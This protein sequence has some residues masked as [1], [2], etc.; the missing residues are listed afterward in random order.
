MGWKLHAPLIKVVFATVLA[1]GTALAFHLRTGDIEPSLTWSTLGWIV[2]GAVYTH[3][4]EYF[5]HLQMMH[6]VIRIARWRFYDTRHLA[7]HRL[8]AGDNFQTRRPEHL[9][10]VT[11]R[12][13][14]FPALFLLHY[15]A[16]RAIFPPDWAPAFF[17]GV[18]VQFLVYEVSHWL[19]HLAEN[20]LD[21]WVRRVP[22]LGD[23]RRRQ[24]E[25]HRTHH[26]RPDVN[27]NFTPP[28]A[29]DYLGRTRARGNMA[30]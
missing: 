19:T 8:F 3:L 21:L 22:V 26:A 28:Y 11:T 10:D 5:Y 30:H 25:H 4:F 7:H 23:I 20:R 12:W 18:S 13:Y 17:L 6:R 9:A 29:G 15:A 16:F 14:T 2:A 27:F 24:I 1:Y